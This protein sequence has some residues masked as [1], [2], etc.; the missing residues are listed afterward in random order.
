MF[1]DEG[2][3]I[4]EIMRRTGY[5]YETVRKYLDMDDFNKIHYPIKDVT[6]LLDPLKPIIDEWLEEDLK[7]PRKQRHTA[8]RVYDRL[9]AEYPKELKVKLRIVQYYVSKKRK[10]LYDEKN[11]GYLPL[12]HPAGETQVDFCKFVYYDNAGMMKAGRKLTISF[13]QSNGAYCQIFRGENKECLLQGIKNIIE[14]IGCVPYRMIFDNLSA[15]VVHINKNKTR[16]LTEEFKRFTTHY[17]IEPVFCN[18][19]S[20]WEKGNVESKV[21]YERRNMFVP[22]P[23]ILDFDEFNKRLLKVCDEDMN[24]THYQKKVL[25]SDLFEADKRAMLPLPEK[26]FHVAKI[27]VLK[28]DKYGK[29]M[30]ESN[31]Y[32][33]SPKLALRTVYLEV[34]SDNVKV[35]NEEYELIVTHSRIYGKGQ[36]AMNWIPYISL[37][38]KRPNALKYTG[39]YH[40]LPD[41]WQTYLKD[42]DK[43]TKR[44]ALLALNCIL[45]KHNIETAAD[46]LSITLANGVKDASSIIASYQ[47]LTNNAPHLKPIKLANNVADMPAFKTDNSSY[48]YLLGMEVTK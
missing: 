20:G 42:A 35:M 45:Q 6:S 37:M 2:V 26:S 17:H 13:P 30:F 38:S 5:H 1:E 25:I 44:E 39:F 4:R 34:S 15:A 40:E 14:Y 22:I 3:S 9:K 10:G 47:Y 33:T 31:K 41:V 21:G 36:E 18:P 16:D 11:K 19:S 29:V 8:K 12:D 28:A 46:A 7:A 48:D 32:S 27:E 24:R 23:T 43:E